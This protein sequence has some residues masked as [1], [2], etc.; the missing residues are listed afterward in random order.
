M[1]WIFSVTDTVLMPATLSGKLTALW[2]LLTRTIQWLTWLTL[3]TT[4]N[5]TAE[6]KE[7]ERQRNLLVAVAKCFLATMSTNTCDAIIPNTGICLQDTCRNCCDKCICGVGYE[8]IKLV[9]ARLR[10][11]LSDELF[12]WM[13]F[14]A[15][16]NDICDNLATDGIVNR[17]ASLSPL[18]QKYLWHRA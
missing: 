16:E 4:D 18:L 5:L 10:S 1:K 2:Q 15:S 13:M 6:M 3:S 12:S 17:F 8:Q 14:L 7:R 9:K 11:T